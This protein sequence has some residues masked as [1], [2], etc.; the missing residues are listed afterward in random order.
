M[1]LIYGEK[2]FLRRFE[3]RMSDA[4]ISRLYKWSRDEELLKLSGGTPTALT[5]SEFREHVRGERLYGPTNR[6]MFLLFARD[7]L[8]LIGR[9]GVF[10]IDWNHRSAEMGIVIGEKEYQNHGYGRDATRTLLQHL[11]TSSSLGLIYLYTFRENV[12][13][14]HAFAAAG[15]RV[16]EQ[17]RR[18]TPDIGEFEGVKMEIMRVEFLR[19]Q[20]LAL[21]ADGNV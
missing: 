7:T 5:E 12:R 3:D 10:A 8:E 6:R 14:Q 20:E 16:T 11:F 15:F 19:Q 18:F 1:A 4:E 17:G 13:A 2:T 21:Q 9:I